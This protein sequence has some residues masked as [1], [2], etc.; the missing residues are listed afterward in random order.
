MNRRRWFDPCLRVLA[1]ACA[2][3][4]MAGALPGCAHF[5]P[6]ATLRA[7]GSR[8]GPSKGWLAHGVRLPERGQGYTVLRTEPE[9][10]Q[11]W[12]TERLVAMVR[13]VAGGLPRPAGEM[14]LVVGDMS[15]RGGGQIPRHQSHRCGRDVDL[16]FFTRDATTGAS[17]LTPGFVRYDRNGAS[18]AWPTPLRFDVE[19]N[20][21]LVER[22]VRD[23]PAGIVRIFIAAWIERLL[24]EYARAHDRAPWVV[25]RAESL[26]VQPGDSL[27]HDDHLHVRVACT[28]GERARGCLDGGPLWPWLQKDWEKGDS[29]PASDDEVLAAL[30]DLPPGVLN[31]PPLPPPEDDPAPEPAVLA[32]ASPVDEA[33]PGL[34]ALPEGPA[35]ATWRAAWPGVGSPPAAWDDIRGVCW[36]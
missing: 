2:A 3:A 11:H 17:V 23:E 29:A 18:V 1:A 21:D 26:M 7:E 19:R 16:L 8:G 20:W 15:G 6:D 10:G 25:E 34:C 27:V 12:A 24:L 5:L 36:R 35:P 32:D 28:P 9:G 30:E 33:L 22:L 4:S 14:P 31:G 13:R